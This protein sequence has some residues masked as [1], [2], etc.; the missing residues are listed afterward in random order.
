MLI[1]DI[2][3]H[4]LWCMGALILKIVTLYVTPF[5]TEHYNSIESYLFKTL[6]ISTFIECFETC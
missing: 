1:A 3:I 2:E 6:I 5:S 4:F